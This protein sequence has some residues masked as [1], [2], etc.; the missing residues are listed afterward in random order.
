MGAIVTVQWE[1]GG[2]WTHGVTVKPNSDDH[3]GC[4]YTNMNDED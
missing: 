4:S 3:R 1:D 2:P